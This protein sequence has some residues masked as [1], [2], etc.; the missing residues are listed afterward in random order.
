M[1]KRAETHVEKGK[2]QDKNTGVIPPIEEKEF[3]KAYLKTNI[4]RP[5]TPVD[6]RDVFKKLIKLLYEKN[7]FYLISA[8]LILYAQS[9]FFRTDNIFINTNIPAV[10]IAVY[11]L[12]MVG[13]AILIV[14]LGKVWDD[15][16]SILAIVLF[17]FMV[18]STSLDG[19]VTNE[20]FQGRLWLLCGFVMSILLSGAVQFSLRIKLS[21]LV[22]IVYT[23]ILG[24]FFAYPVLLSHLVHTYE[25]NTIPAIRGI[26]LFPTV[27]AVLFLLLIPA[28]R[29]GRKY[30]GDTGTPWK[31]PLF[32][33]SI[34][35]IFAVGVVLRSYLLTIS[36]Y[37][38][39]GVGPYSQLE[40]GFGL[41]MLVPFLLSITVLLTEYAVKFRRRKLQ[42]VIL[43]VPALLMLCALHVPAGTDAANQF[44]KA[45]GGVKPWMLTLA[46]SGAFYVYTAIRG[47]KYS[48]VMLM[49][50]LGIASIAEVSTHNLAPMN[51][52]DWMFPAILA[53]FVMVEAVRRR[54]A[55][56]CVALSAIITVTVSY[57]LRDT[58]FMMFKGAIPGHIIFLVMFAAGAFYSD[59]SADVFRT[60]TA[61]ALPIMALGGVIA[62]YNNE[63]PMPEALTYEAAMI[64]LTL[65]GALWID[66][67]KYLIPLIASAGLP[68]VFFSYKYYRMLSREI[69]GMGVI[70]WGI[71]CF[72]AA[73]IISLNKG[74]IINRCRRAAAK[75]H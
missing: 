56:W 14:R 10:L 68:T 9:V 70:F 71:V 44:L 58:Q 54:T 35:G 6:I 25:K 32:P 59:T 74:R 20:P 61:V 62:G 50:V 73:L 57:Y 60:I 69:N 66:R 55:G 22:S 8:M 23:L 15:A 67:R 2:T 51:V 26:M 42:A 39:K 48:Q 63:I 4:N 36:F 64:T 53:T 17:L 30:F 43:G 49:G 21:A 29:G 19:I 18:M 5:I 11:T 46:L 33:W 7:P 75:N 47:V 52:P 34:F 27:A 16:A 12:M 40:S 65:T 72:I 38:G 31:W 41:Y 1:E 45:L 24:L 3:D 37:G 13:A 28:V